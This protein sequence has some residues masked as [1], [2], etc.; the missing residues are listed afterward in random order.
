M[1]TLGESGP[2][3]YNNEMHVDFH[4]AQPTN[5]VEDT[6]KTLGARHRKAALPG[7]YAT[8]TDFCH[9]FASDMDRLF[10]LSLLL[11]ADSELAEKCFVR[12]LEDSKSGN[13]V[14]K[15]WAESWAQRTIVQNAIR[16]VR[17]R[18]RDF[19]S[20]DNVK[21]CDVTQPAEIAA[22]VALPAFDRFAYVLSVL[23]GYPLRECA[24]L[25]GCTPGE[26]NAARM[27]AL[28]EVVKSVEG[29]EQTAS[30]RTGNQTL[31]ETDQLDSL[32]RLAA[33]A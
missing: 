17:P 19:V 6:V 8:S 15:E 27:R 11:T 5:N 23:E 30:I 13:P 3:K 10:L 21:S 28:Q 1:P 2:R 12:G 7:L 14:F 4:L 29:R 22:V 9:I 24:L 33:T 16:M 26:V 32:S 25:L 20:S 31:R 18:P